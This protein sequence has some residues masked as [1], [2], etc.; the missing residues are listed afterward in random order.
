MSHSDLA[1]R[2]GHFCSYTYFPITCANMLDSRNTTVYIIN[3][4]KSVLHERNYNFFAWFVGCFKGKGYSLQSKVRNA[5]VHR[6]LLFVSQFAKPQNE[7]VN[8][9]KRL[10]SILFVCVM[11]F[12]LA[13]SAFA[14]EAD[15]SAE[16]EAASVEVVDSVPMSSDQTAQTRG[17]ATVKTEP[18]RPAVRKWSIHG[19]RCSQKPG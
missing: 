7:R 11:M 4:I 6:R 10:I 13:T 16:S 8:N 19:T 14:A 18:L 3:T 15:G 9:M 12:G 5:S 1:V 2:V 17:I